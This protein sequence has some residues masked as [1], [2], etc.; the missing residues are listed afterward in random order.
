MKGIELMNKAIVLSCAAV[1]IGGMSF[2]AV[3]PGEYWVS[4]DGK[5][6]AAYTQE[7]PGAFPVSKEVREARR[8]AGQG[9]PKM[10]TTVFTKGVYE[11]TKIFPANPKNGAALDV[12]TKD[13][14]L[15]NVLKGVTGNAADVIFEGRGFNARAL[16]LNGFGP[17]RIS[18]ITFRNF[19]TKGDGGAVVVGNGY[20]GGGVWA[21][22]R[23]CI[24]ERNCA[25]H[26]GG[27]VWGLVEIR[28]SRF[29][30]NVAM[31]GSGGAFY[32]PRTWRSVPQGLVENCVFVDNVAPEY[33]MRAEDTTIA[34]CVTV[35]DSTVESWRR[36]L[37]GK[38]KGPFID[39]IVLSPGDDLLVA[40]DRLRMERNGKGN[41]EIVLKDGY[42][43]ITNAIALG[44][45]DS[46][47]TIRAEH[48]G[49]A[50]VT[51]AA[52]IPGRSFRRDGNLVRAKVDEACRV[53][54]TNAVRPVLSIDGVAMTHA[55][56]P[57]IGGVLVTEKNI[58]ADKRGLI[59]SDDRAAK[60]TLGG[61][62]VEGFG[63]TGKYA[64]GGRIVTGYDAATKALRF[65]DPVGSGMR[66]F[67][68]G[69][70]EEVDRLGEWAYDAKAGEIVLCPPKGFTVKSTV[71]LGLH[72]NGLFNVTGDGVKFVGV[73]F[74]AVPGCKGQAISVSYGKDCRI[75]GCTFTAFGGDAV[76]LAGVRG[77]VQ[78]CDF[79]DIYGCCVRVNAGDKKLLMPGGCVV[80]N[81]LFTRPCLMRNG[82]AC[83]AV[84]LDG[85]E[86]RV[87]HCVIHQTREHALDWSGFGCVVEYC[88]MF[89]ATLEFRDSGVVYSPGCGQ[90]SYGCHFRFNDISG[91]PGLA[92]GIYPDDFSSGHLIYGNVV[93]NIGWGA[94]FLGGGR[95]NLISNNVITATGAMAL[96]ND[97]RGLWWPAW[98]DR[99]KW[100]KDAIRLLDYVDGPIGKRWPAYAHWIDDG[101]NMFGN[102]DNTWV[103]NVVIDSPN[104]Q[105]QA[106]HNIFIPLDRQASRGNASFGLR[107][108]PCKDV[109]RFGGFTV[110]DLRGTS[111]RLFVNVPPRRTMKRPDGL[112]LFR[113]ERGDFNLAPDSAVRKAVPGFQ[114]IPWD[115]I[116]LYTDD[117]RKTLPDVKPL[118]YTGSSV[119]EG[120][121]VMEVIRVKSKD[122]GT[123]VSRTAGQFICWVHVRAGSRVTVLVGGENFKLEPNGK[124]GEWAWVK[125]GKVMLPAGYTAV[126]APKGD[127]DEI[128]L[129]N[130]PKWTPEGK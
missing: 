52:I 54:L 65:K 129:V 1:C 16:M 60:W 106:C 71:A 121:A 41:A 34:A 3:V 87:S 17:H 45:L 42:Y 119:N 86:N 130:D 46:R 125:A 53:M 49:K 93:R 108:A 4:P 91:A 78:S 67:F 90:S 88:R 62:K 14:V 40:R 28:N 89:D 36:D 29:I 51:A 19:T 107:S 95:D 18:G 109:W 98:K 123:V 69:V 37:F 103:N 13:A 5:A 117:W 38:S 101:T 70:L 127:V 57:D 48:P 50:F 2:G 104:T 43:T 79:T 113:Y 80:D 25:A 7:A 9:E 32:G 12:F 35:R 126:S 97:N 20:T 33:N 105:D 59:L 56:W 23:D 77:A 66:F 85:V 96:H 128:V 114:P 99:E 55:R 58:A 81:C 68:H 10:M 63:M 72:G 74:T 112:E 11:F 84:R 15:T 22:I 8:K 115:K 118:G 76:S 73:A 61:A 102:V 31:T 44:G 94:I 27:A 111:D 120:F 100:H 122:F 30:Q 124:R 47:L 64:S 83:G 110:T 21:E 24:F 82:C 75:E 6:D 92:H 26:D 39:R 116:G